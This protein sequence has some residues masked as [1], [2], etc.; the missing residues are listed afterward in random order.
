MIIPAGPKN[1]QKLTFSIFSN[2]NFW[3]FAK[4]LNNDADDTVYEISLPL[5]DP[6]AVDYVACQCK[7]VCCRIPLGQGLQGRQI[8]IC[9]EGGFAPG[10]SVTVGANCPQILH[11]LGG[12]NLKIPTYLWLKVQC[13]FEPCKNRFSGR[14]TRRTRKKVFLVQKLTFYC[15]LILAFD[16][17]ETILHRKFNFLIIWLR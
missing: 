10:F 2:Y 17:F 14:I 7:K 9:F 12:K 13:F 3:F 4:S 16:V 11:Y 15:I 6:R 1:D 5:S 8:Q